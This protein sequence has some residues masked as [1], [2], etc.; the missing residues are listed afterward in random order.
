MRYLIRILVALLCFC[1]IAGAATV[2]S[3]S[4]TDTHLLRVACVG[5]SITYGAGLTNRARDAWP[6]VLG[7]ML[8]PHWDVRNFG[9]S[10]RTLLKAGDHPYWI[11]RAFTN[12]LE[13]KPDVLIILLGTNDSKRPTKEF[14]RAPDNWQHHDEFQSDYEEMIA[15]FRRANPD[16]K[17]YVCLPPPAF[18]GRW[19][20][21]EFTM[22]NAVA[23]LIRQVARTTG[24]TLI[25]L[26][27]P[28]ATHPEMFPDTV[29]PDAAG[30]RLIAA[31][32]YEALQGRPAPNTGLSSHP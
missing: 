8:G 16:V 30:A 2:A 25:D 11:E 18:P 23:P 12:A 17:I 22:T 26:H 14:P 31:T 15:E 5:D 28:L 7:R 9:V 13:F 10:G 24:A 27:T 20:I 32:V 4:Q 3:A 1:G 6:A 19:G 21:S 29:H